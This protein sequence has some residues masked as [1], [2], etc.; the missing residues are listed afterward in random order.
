MADSVDAAEMM[1]SARFFI[2]FLFCHLHCVGF[3][4]LC[5]S[6]FIDVTWLLPLQALHVHPGQEEEK[7]D[8]TD[9]ILALIR[10][11]KPFDFLAEGL[12]VNW[13]KRKNGGKKSFP[14]SKMES[15]SHF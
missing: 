9:D 11:S 7:R 15:H 3:L 1:L 12:Q 2:V 5:L 13:L 4:T 6:N 8:D 14:E 10:K